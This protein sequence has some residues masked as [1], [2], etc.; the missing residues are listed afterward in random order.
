MQTLTARPPTYTPDMTT[1]GQVLTAQPFSYELSPLIG[2]P[3]NALRVQP[4]YN[5]RK[6][7][8]TVAEDHEGRV[9]HLA[10]FLG[11]LFA[12]TENAFIFSLFTL[13]Q[14]ADQNWQTTSWFF[15]SYIAQ[16]TPSQSPPPLGSYKKNIASGTLTR[17][18]FGVQTLLD[19]LKDPDGDMIYYAMT[20]QCLQSFVRAMEALVLTAMIN[21]RAQYLAF[22]VEASDYTVNVKSR[23]V[24][25]ALTWDALHRYADAVPKLVGLVQDS[26]GQSQ[27]GKATAVI[28]HQG[29]R[30]LVAS[31]PALTD[32]YLRG[33]GSSTF[34]DRRGDAPGLQG[35]LLGTDIDMF[36]ASPINATGQGVFI[37]VLARTVEI[38]G[39]GA[40]DNYGWNMS[41]DLYTSTMTNTGMFDMTQGNFKDLTLPRALDWVGRFDTSAAGNLVPLDGAPAQQVPSSFNVPAEFKPATADEIAL[42]EVASLYKL[43]NVQLPA[44]T[45]LLGAFNYRAGY[46]RKDAA[47]I[48]KADGVFL[49]VGTLKKAP[50]V[51]M[52]VDSQLIAEEPAEAETGDGD[53]GSLF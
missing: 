11:N 17:Y 29:F 30:S 14:F 48:S 46:E 7:F 33:P 32:Y 16:E 34:A 18:A 22:W 6:E 49:L 25:E 21:T 40:I 4:G 43:E 5:I 10:V 27:R 45:K 26:F 47:I 41:T 8:T 52:E 13:K 37:D 3:Q 44:E 39:Y 24:T 42:L 36:V 2:P 19:T 35:K 31:S 23:A 28:V 15:D 38:G 50:F 53:F 1:M 12:E 51:G 9:E 20:V